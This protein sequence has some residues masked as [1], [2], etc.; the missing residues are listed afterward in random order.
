MPNTGTEVSNPFSTGGGGPNFETYVQASFVVLMLAGGHVPCLP[1][2]PIIKIKLQGRS[3]GYETDDLIV[4]MQGLRAGDERK[5]LG[6]IKHSISIT[7]Q[8]PEF[9]KVIQAAWND[10]NNTEVFNKGKD[11]IALITG[12]LSATDNNVRTIL[13]W[14]RSV[15]NSSEFFRRVEMA[16]VSSAQKRIKLKAFEEN[17]KKANGNIDVD[18]EK[19]FEFLRHFHLVGYDLDIRNGVTLALL[20]SLIGQY[21]PDDA[22]SIWGKLV[23]EVMAANQ[24]AGTISNSNISE[25]LRNAFSRLAE[26]SIPAEYVAPAPP[27]IIFKTPSQE[28]ALTVATLLGKWDENNEADLQIIRRLI[29]GF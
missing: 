13:D 19:I 20:N 6:Q 11:V 3:A 8:G 17:L 27:N 12:P 24:N 10:F 28:L 22:H 15:E 25:D 23:L 9:K 1:D 16:N 21:S 4:F 29:D 5:L 7:S 2:R 26:V 18:K 14:A